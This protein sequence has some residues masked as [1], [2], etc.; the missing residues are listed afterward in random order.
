MSTRQYKELKGLHKENLRDNMS[1]LELILNMLAEATTTEL[2][3]EKNPRGYRK[4]RKSR[5]GA[6]RSPERPENRSRIRP[7]SRHPRARRFPAA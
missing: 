5:S 3:R 6:A 4:A 2:S 7:E 1:N